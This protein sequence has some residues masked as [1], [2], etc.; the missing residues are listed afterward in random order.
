M[1]S[2]RR[3]SV[4]KIQYATGINYFHER[5]LTVPGALA[6][7]WKDSEDNPMSPSF[8]PLEAR[9]PQAQ[10]RWWAGHNRRR[11]QTPVTGVFD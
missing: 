3:L 10:A 2:W 9:T 4:A 5:S 8:V 1:R 7:A 11:R 6:G